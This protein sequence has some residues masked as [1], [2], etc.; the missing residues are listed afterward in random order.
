MGGTGAIRNPSSYE[1]KAAAQP[2][3][4]L[5][6]LDRSRAKKARAEKTYFLNTHSTFR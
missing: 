6:L 5:Q 1:S 2:L 3:L 4:D